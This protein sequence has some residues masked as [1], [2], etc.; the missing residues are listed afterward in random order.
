MRVFCCCFL[1]FTWPGV[2]ILVRLCDGEGHLSGM[3][4][5]DCFSLVT[6]LLS[7]GCEAGVDYRGGKRGI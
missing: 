7:S 5:L 6:S 1:S 4:S 3:L 2:G